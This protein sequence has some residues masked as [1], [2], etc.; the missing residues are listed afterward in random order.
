M[1]FA[2]IAKIHTTKSPIYAVSQIDMELNEKMFKMLEDCEKLTIMKYWPSTG[3]S[4]PT[5]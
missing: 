1:S 4:C 5:M 3:Y 2:I